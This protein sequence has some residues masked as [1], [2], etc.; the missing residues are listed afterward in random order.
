MTLV[1][2]ELIHPFDHYSLSQL[3]IHS[4]IT[5]LFTQTSIH[6]IIRTHS[7]RKNINKRGVQ[8]E[9]KLNCK[10]INKKG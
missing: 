1:N 9:F 10:V 2:K 6:S 8:W 7:A 4:F 3:F 5:R